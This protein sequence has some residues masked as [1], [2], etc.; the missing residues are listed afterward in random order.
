MPQMETVHQGALL[1][2]III[3]APVFQQLILDDCALAIC[4]HQQLRAYF[5]GKTIH[6]K[7]MVGDPLL[8]N[9]GVGQAISTGEKVVRKMGA[10]LF[11]IPYIVVAVPVVEKGKGIVGGISLSMSIEREQQLFS[12]A[13]A[14]QQYIEGVTVVVTDLNQKASQLEQLESE[15]K[16]IVEH[17][18]GTAKESI[19]LSQRIKQLAKETGIL[20]LNSGIEAARQ[21]ENGKVF[22]TVAM[23]MRGL[24]TNVNQ[25]VEEI[26]HNLEGIGE[27]SQKL[28]AQLHLL[29]DISARINQVSKQLNGQIY[30][31][32]RIIQ[33]LIELEEF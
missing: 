14:L 19:G 27:S 10:E 5:P 4:D 29:E 24:A 17:S 11:G 6:Q 3:S 22:N 25:S 23:R 13:K 7:V 32:K 9:S 1:D 18:Y 31:V 28:Q 21:G 12:I 20:A 30:E 15:W 26:V 8:P 2:H 33:R 16:E